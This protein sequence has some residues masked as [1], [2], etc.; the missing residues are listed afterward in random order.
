M[1][2]QS[3]GAELANK[4]KRY[5]L[6]C[7]QCGIE[8]MGLMTQKRRAEEGKPVY[9]PGNTC[10][11]KAYYQRRRLRRVDHVFKRAYDKCMSLQQK[12]RKAKRAALE[13]VEVYKSGAT[14]H[15]SVAHAVALFQS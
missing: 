8:F 9:C 11:F 6:T 10:N 15:Q 5:P 13:A 1:K 7:S 12:P 14:I 3:A 2:K 4:R